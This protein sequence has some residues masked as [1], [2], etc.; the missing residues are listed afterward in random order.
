MPSAR[1]I[2]EVITRLDD[3]I[4]L[5]RRERSR[6]GY[7]PALYR[8]VTLRVKQGIAAGEFEDGPR[9]EQLDVVFANRYLEAYDQQRAGDRPTH[10]WALAF[11]ATRAWSPIVLQHLLLGM[12]AH[13]NLDLGIAAATIAPGSELPR[14]RA[15]FVKINEVLNSLVDT[16]KGELARIWAPL[17]PLDR[18]SGRIED[19]VAEFSMGK[20]RD[21][22]WQFAETLA[23]HEGPARADAIARRD[24]WTSGFGLCVRHPPL[25]RL[26]VLFIRLGER[27]DVSENIEILCGEP[28]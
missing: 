24:V 21:D 28:R 18:M 3:I 23:Q 8:K 7:F 14:L 6:V 26:G 27:R 5:A 19:V 1:T 9:M 22:A 25:G 17:G 10:A 16:V 15:D 13:I 11:A 4:A 20:A 12:N 2:D